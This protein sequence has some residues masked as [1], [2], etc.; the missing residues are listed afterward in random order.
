MN[1][2]VKISLLMV[3]SICHHNNARAFNYSVS[4]N[5]PSVIKQN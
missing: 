1:K 4:D 5:G 3:V 2:F